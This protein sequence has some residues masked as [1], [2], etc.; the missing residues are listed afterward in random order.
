MD[1]K[2]FHILDNQSWAGVIWAYMAI[3]CTIW[4][5]LNNGTILGSVFQHVGFEMRRANF[6]LKT[7]GVYMH[8]GCTT[9]YELQPHHCH[10]KLYK[11]RGYV[12]KKRKKQY[13]SNTV[14]IKCDMNTIKRL[15]SATRLVIP[16]RYFIL[17]PMCWNSRCHCRKTALQ[18]QKQ[19]STPQCWPDFTRFFGTQMFLFFSLPSSNFIGTWV[20]AQSIK[21]AECGLWTYLNMWELG[22]L[23]SPTPA[24]LPEVALE[25]KKRKKS[26]ILWRKNVVN[27]NYSQ[28]ATLIFLAVHS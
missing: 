15:K 17:N 24:T 16:S 12:K 9:V 3:K 8:T 7:E 23:H 19:T 28:I 1:I 26:F 21:C 14:Q 11:C 25:E 4:D 2:C 22:S 5:N 13:D 10:V 18:F 27:Y 20:E 6:H